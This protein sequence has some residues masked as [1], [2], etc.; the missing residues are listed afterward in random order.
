MHNGDCMH[1]PATLIKLYIRWQSSIRSSIYL[2]L[3]PFWRDDVI[4]SVIER[5]FIF[6]NY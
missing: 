5:P 3:I 2:G 1:R 6:S 4:H